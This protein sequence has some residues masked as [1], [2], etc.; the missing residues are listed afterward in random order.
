MGGFAG[1]P[2]GDVSDADNRNAETFGFQYPGIEKEIPDP[3]NNAVD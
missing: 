3:D 2:D 1:A